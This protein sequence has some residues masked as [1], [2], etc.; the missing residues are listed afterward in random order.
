MTMMIMCLENSFGCR[1][2]I[3]LPTYTQMKQF[4]GTL[5]NCCKSCPFN[6]CHFL[7]CS[8]FSDFCSSARHSHNGSP[9][10]QHLALFLRPAAQ[11]AQLRKSTVSFH[12]DASRHRFGSDRIGWGSGS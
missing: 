7:F 12:N 4:F 1:E 10:C 5:Y 6:M 3:P 8:C 9:N 11:A 2:G